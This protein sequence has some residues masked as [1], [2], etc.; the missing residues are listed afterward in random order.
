MGSL[1]FDESTLD[2]LPKGPG[3]YIFMDRAGSII[4]VGKA[5][6]LSSRVRSYFSKGRANHGNI[7]SVYLSKKI[8]SLD[9]ISTDNELEA[10]IL[11]SN[12]IKKNRPRYNISLKDD[13][14]YPFLALTLSQDF[15]RVLITRNRGIKG[16]K[17]FGPYTN[18][19]SLRTIVEYLNKIFKIRDCRGSRPGKVKDKPCLNY[20]IELCSGPCVKLISSEQYRRNIETIISLL[21]GKD[22]KIIRS[23]KAQMEKCAR[24][25]EFEKALLLREKIEAIHELYGTQRI[26]LQSENA[27]DFIAL[28]RD[29][30]IAC[31]DGD[32]VQG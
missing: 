17:Y 8:A 4:Y 12:L 31:S 10:L 23:L 6:N 3:V 14:S 5:K 26:F 15:P 9:Y 2:A 25:K 27:K 19:Q 16:A 1:K 22:K 7:R 21:K 30:D 13:K 24:E 28:Y 11:E 29:A 20:H 18:V 32:H